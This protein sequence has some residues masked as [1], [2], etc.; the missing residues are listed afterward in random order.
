MLQTTEQ[1]PAAETSYW[2]EG[3]QEPRRDLILAKKSRN[4]EDIRRGRRNPHGTL[5]TKRKLRWASRADAI[6]RDQDWPNY[7]RSSRSRERPGRNPRRQGVKKVSARRGNS[8]SSPSRMLC[9]GSEEQT[10]TI[11]END[12][13]Y[14]PKLSFHDFTKQQMKWTLDR[15]SGALGPDGIAAEELRCLWPHIQDDL[16]RCLNQDVSRGEHPF[17]EATVTL[18]PKRGRDVIEP[19]G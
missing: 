16:V 3:C 4:S 17:K 9:P 2:D 12:P 10:P 8:N 15:P 18:V 1:Q 19:N 5:K 14:P 7:S 11:T 13:G 6:T